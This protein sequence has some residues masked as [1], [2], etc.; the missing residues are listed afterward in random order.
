MRREAVTLRL[1]DS[2]QKKAAIYFIDLLKAE[3]KEEY[4]QL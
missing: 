3:D 4:N 2:Y 1:K